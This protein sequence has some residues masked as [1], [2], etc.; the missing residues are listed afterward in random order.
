MKIIERKYYIS[1]L[2]NVIGTPEIKI[3]TGIRRSGKS[4][5][6]DIFA[7]QILK[8][9]ANANIIRIKLNVKKFEALK[10]ADKL[11]EYVDSNYIAGVNN[12]LFIDEVQLCKG[13]ESSIISF[14]EEERYD[15]Y[16]TGS[17]AFLLSSDLATLFGGRAFEINMFPFSFSEYRV[18]Y[19]EGDIDLD[20][21][22]YVVNGGMSGSYLYNTDQDKKRYLSAVVKT[23][24]VRDIVEKFKIENENLL[25][26]IVDFLMDNIGSQTSVRNISNCLS[27]NTYKTNDKTCGAYLDY[28]SRCFLFYPIK[29]YDIRGKRYLESDM[30]YYLADVSFRYALLGTK[31]TDYGHIY[32][33]IVAIELLR[34]GYEVYVG[35]LY[36]KEV[37][38]VAIKDGV[39]HYIQVSDNIA[40]KATFNR[41]IKPLLSIRDAYPKMIIART[42][43]EEYQVEGV[44][45]IDIARW[46]VLQK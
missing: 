3:I 38:F 40:E 19:P 23:T 41:E 6:L 24:I 2:F 11:Y 36:D 27:S 5:L 1:Q 9:E 14:H 25:I 34:R 21:D 39:K 29:R 13:F 43:H 20:F 30:K 17:N 33:N 16:L 35:K 15:I 42:K 31:N 10:D 45:I 37:D 22:N 44:I 7:E 4:K 8:N 28:L 12:Y 32:E 46:L 26:H 18:Y